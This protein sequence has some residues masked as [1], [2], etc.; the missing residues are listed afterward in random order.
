MTWTIRYNTGNISWS[1]LVGR[2][3]ADMAIGERGYC[4]PWA[5]D[6]NY[7]NLIYSVLPYPNGTCDVYVERKQHGFLVRGWDAADGVG[8]DWSQN[9]NRMVVL[10]L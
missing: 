9:N 1:Q 6:G 5:I 8:V 2:K 10:V 3:L 7:I 4:V